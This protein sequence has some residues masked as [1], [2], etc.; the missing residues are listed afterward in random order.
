MTLTTIPQRRPR[1]GLHS[2]KPRHPAGHP[3][4]DERQ[5]ARI[6]ARGVPRRL[7]R[8][9]LP[10]RT[11][12]RCLVSTRLRARGRQARRPGRR[13]VRPAAR[14]RSRPN[15]TG[16]RAR[17]S[18][19]RRPGCLIAK[20]GAAR[21]VDRLAPPP[22][23][24]THHFEALSHSEIRV[25]R[26][27]PTN[28]SAREIVGELYVSVNTVKTHRRYLYQKARRTQPHPGRRAGP[29]PRPARTSA[30]RA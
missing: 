24:Q 25:L 22:G 2:G 10:G 8:L 28:L 7:T 3:S 4:N 13:R 26:Y 16:C 5:H 30:A 11:S 27:L 29:R 15:L 17:S 12:S 9:S 21:R 18:S 19:T 23:Q 6:P 1:P 14:P 20:C